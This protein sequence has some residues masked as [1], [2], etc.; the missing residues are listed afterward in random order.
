MQLARTGERL[1]NVLEVE[2]GGG[3]GEFS[4]RVWT[5]NGFTVY[6]GYKNYNEM[7]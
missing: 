1:L 7:E 6:G 5:L 4:Y 2:H 3:G